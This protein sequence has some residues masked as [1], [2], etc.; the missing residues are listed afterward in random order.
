MIL[1]N[2][3]PTV[4]ACALW[5]GMED[6]D[7]APLAGFLALLISALIG[8]A[9]TAFFLNQRMQEE[10][11]KWTW[12]SIW[13]EA[14]FSNIFALKD[15]VEPT[16]QYIPNIWA[17][18][19]KGVIPQIL[20]V[21]FISAAATKVDGTNVFWHYGNYPA[22]PYQFMGVV[23][24]VFALALFVAGFFFPGMYAFLATAFEDQHHEE[25]KEVKVVADSDEKEVKD[26]GSVDNIKAA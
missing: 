15:R 16:I 8:V 4:L 24:I 18:L 25:V 21:V 19:I 17:Y 5:F 13:F 12:R 1:A 20:I 11:G 10:P 26:E 22:M 7:A 2:F 9:V 6:P 3:F 14:T 23:C